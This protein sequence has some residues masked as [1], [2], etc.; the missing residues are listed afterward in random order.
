MSS[1]LQCPRARGISLAAWS[2]ETPKYTHPVRV[3]TVEQGE[4]IVRLLGARSQQREPGRGDW[5][6]VQGI[7]GSGAF[8][9][10]MPEAD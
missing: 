6:V 4:A 3:V 7:H 8:S 5:F 1:C 2:R 10:V 9:I